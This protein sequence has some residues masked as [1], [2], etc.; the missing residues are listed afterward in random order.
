MNHHLPESSDGSDDEENDD[1][2]YFEPLKEDPK[3]NKRF[4]YTST[5]LIEKTNIVR[6]KDFEASPSV[7][8]FTGF[9]VGKEY[10]ITLNII[11]CGK[12]KERMNVMPLSS[13]IF[14]VVLK[15]K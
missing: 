4:S 6:S 7:I 12:Y 14:L 5:S 15:Y 1:I 2:N 3:K 8:H 13:S 10:S 9:N 11:N